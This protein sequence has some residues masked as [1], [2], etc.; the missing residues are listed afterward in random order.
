M[1]KVMRSLV[2]GPLAPYVIEFADGLLEQGYTQFSAAQHVG[3]IAHLD[4]WLQ[5]E[6][7]VIGDL[8]EAM[9]ARYLQQRRAAGYV[10][11]RT[12]RALAPL[13]SFLA[14]KAVL[15]AAPPAPPDP[16]Q[17]LLDRYRD[18]LLSERGLS[19]GTVA[20]YAHRARRFLASRPAGTEVD[21]AG[22]GGAEVLEYVRT[23][24]PG[25][26][27]GSA[28]MI[29][30]VLRS[31][32]NWLHLTGMI[33]VPL[34]PVVP[35]VAGW[36]LAGVPQPLTPQQLQ[37]LLTSC[38]RRRPAGRRDYAILVV[39]SRLGLRA[40]EVAN[41]GLDDIDWRAGQLRVRGKGN[42]R[43]VLPLPADVGAAIV[44][45]LRHGRPVSAQER[46]VFVRVRA[47]HRT[48]TAGGVGNVVTAAGVR[49]GLGHVHAHQ[50]RHTVA[51]TM[52]RAGSSLTEVGQVLRHRSPLTTAI[53]AKVD[54]DALTVL[55]RPWPI[56][57]SDGAS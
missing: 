12:R 53:Y 24:C 27:K 49:A 30:T 20:G 46:S 42:R 22:L 9:I 54:Q 21:L 1:V 33:P 8:D 2:V 45:Y 41:L 43:E 37:A 13:L 19:V 16:V 26:A 31:L 11:Y 51:T 55:A 7:L 36:Q 39:L 17:E 29:V 52:L 34:A 18:Y 57:V 44:S 6:G 4:R 14:A 10:E 32:L 35:S 48:L 38:D 56:P 50:L 28:K 47:P 15:P 5:A 3:F 23:S 25:R 40:G